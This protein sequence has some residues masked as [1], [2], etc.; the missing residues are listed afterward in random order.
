M[1]SVSCKI[2]VLIK[3]SAYV[4]TVYSIV[5]YCM[6]QMKIYFR[7]L[8]NFTWLNFCIPTRYLFIPQINVLF[9][10]RSL[11]GGGEGVGVK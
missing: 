9:N 10:P 1:Y 3:A 8:L 4:H 6:L 7:S 5:I 11:E 2:L